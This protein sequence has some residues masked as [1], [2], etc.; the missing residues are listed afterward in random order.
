MDKAHWRLLWHGW[1]PGCRPWAAD[2]SQSAGSM[3]ETALGSCSSG[4]INEWSVR[5]GFDPVE[6]AAEMPDVPNVWSDGSLVRSGH[7]C[8]FFWEGA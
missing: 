1:L 6:A 3:V 5:E 4:L 2:A 7:R 8:F